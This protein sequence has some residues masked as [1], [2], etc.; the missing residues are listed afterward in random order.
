MSGLSENFVQR[1]GR[2]PALHF[3]AQRIQIEAARAVVAGQMD[4]VPDPIEIHR[5]VFAIV[6]QQRN[7]HARNGGGL[8]KRKSL[9]QNREA[10]HA[11]NGVD[12]PGL[13]QS[14]HQRRPFGDKHGVPQTLGLHLQILNRAQPALFAQQ[15][16]FIEGRRALVFDAQALGKQQ[17]AAIVRHAGKLVAPDFVVEQHPGVV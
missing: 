8:H 4:H 2:E 15:A 12:L 3:L 5:R 9:F 16:E 14:H 17:Q 10:A 1:S 13:N 7:R 6:L 11:D